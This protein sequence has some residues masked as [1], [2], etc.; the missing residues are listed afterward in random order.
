MAFVPSCSLLI[1]G[2]FQKQIKIFLN[3]TWEI[4]PSI[5]I[6]FHWYLALKK[7]I[8]QQT[9]ETHI[10]CALCVLINIY[11]WMNLFIKLL[12]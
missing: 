1:Q 8:Y 11:I 9:S 7:M 12:H 5:E 10:W 6:P 2:F 3:K 4:C